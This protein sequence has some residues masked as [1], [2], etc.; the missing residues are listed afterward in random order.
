M[1]GWRQAGRQSGR[2]AGRQA[3]RELY[4]HE[5]SHGVRAPSLLSSLPPSLILSDTLTHTCA[6]SHRGGGVGVP[7]AEEARLEMIAASLVAAVRAGSAQAMPSRISL[8]R[9]Y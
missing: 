6:Y 2:Q 4:A 8:E 1:E 7:E 3:G 9:G 5:S